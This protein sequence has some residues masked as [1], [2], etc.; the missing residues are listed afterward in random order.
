MAHAEKNPGPT[1]VSG[2][3]PTNLYEAKDSSNMS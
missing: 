2:T 3:T 1:E